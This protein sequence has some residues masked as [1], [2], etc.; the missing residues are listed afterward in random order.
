MITV[1]FLGLMCMLHF[2]LLSLLDFLYS[3]NTL[4]VISL[5]NAYNL[6]YYFEFIR[7]ITFNLFHSDLNHLLINMISF[8]NFGIPVEDFFNNF[9]KFLY[10]KII[11]QLAFFTGIFSFIFNFLCYYFTNN[12]YYLIVKLNGFSGVLFGL[13]YIFYY[14]HTN[15]K[16]ESIKRVLIHLFYISLVTRG[17]S[18]IGHFSGIC[19]GVLVNNLIGI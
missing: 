12:Q 9:N 11:F 19:S 2:R 1:Y 6:S 4:S 10:P 3:Y 7:L 8:I 16:Q 17:T 14:L 5:F 18:F 13:Q 15:S